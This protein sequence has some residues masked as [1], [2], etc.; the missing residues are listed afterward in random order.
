MVDKSKE[1][2]LMTQVQG[3]INGNGAT[4]SLESED[5]S[6]LNIANLGDSKSKVGNNFNTVLNSLKSITDFNSYSTE[7]E[8][9]SLLQYSRDRKTDQAQRAGA[10]LIMAAKNAAEYVKGRFVQK[11]GDN[12]VLADINSRYSGDKLSNVSLESFDESTMRKTLHAN[13]VAVMNIVQQDDFAELFFPIYTVPATDMGFTL[14]VPVESIWNGLS[15]KPNGKPAEFDRVPVI[16][17][18]RDGDILNDRSTDLVPIYRDTGD[19]TVVNQDKFVDTTKVAART[20]TIDGVDV[21][22]ATLKVGTDIDLIG[23]STT[24]KLAERG[25]LDHTDSVDGTIGLSRIY[26]NTAGGVISFDVKDAPTS[27]FRANPEG[28]YRQEGLQFISRNLF[29][30]GDTVLND[31]SVPAEAA[32]LKA[33]N[34]KALLDIKLYGTINLE[35]S[36]VNVTAGSSTITRAWQDGKEISIDDAG[37][38]TAIGNLGKQ[39]AVIGWDPDARRTNLNIVSLGKRIE[40]SIYL[41]QYKPEFHSP[42]SIE[43]SLVLNTDTPTVDAL[44]RATKITMSNAAVYRLNDI[45]NLLQN[46]KSVNTELDD[47]RSGYGGPARFS[48][49]PY[50]QHVVLDARKIVNNVQSAQKTEDI[51][52]A[53]SAVLTYLVGDALQNTSYGEVLRIKQYGERPLVG[54]GTSEKIAPYLM[55]DGDYRL[56]GNNVDYT[57][58][59]TTN[60]LMDN[61]IYATFIIN[62]KDRGN[63]P[64]ELDFGYCVYC[65]EFFVNTPRSNNNSTTQLMQIYPVYK[66]CFNLPILIRITLMN[67]DE[68]V[69]EEISKYFAD[70]GSSVPGAGGGGSVPGGGIVRMMEPESS[71]QDGTSGTDKDTTQ[72][73]S[74]KGNANKGAPQ[75]P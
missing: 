14:E 61:E 39:L 60:K 12:V 16:K 26:L 69:S 53:L 55:R 40:Q 6:K 58:V 36:L 24:D 64:N 49:R 17:G 41:L 43:K 18:L 70:A 50:V 30:T 71:A 46:V 29:I 37:F 35:S 4:L 44:V 68:V 65:P 2:A 28:H 20:V 19:A 27:K 3:I 59:T 72:Q 73:S 45:F 62:P 10:Y 1:K 66:H 9:G 47:V 33:G 11:S 8:A 56:V 13:V 32:A 23:V 22:T 15:H 21:Q 51:Q 74:G 63:L 5:F 52:G 67:L 38:K 48:I 57:I 42:I 25:L 34:Y 31:N 75:K 54:I 7:A